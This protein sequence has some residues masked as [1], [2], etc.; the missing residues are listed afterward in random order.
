V[1]LSIERCRVPPSNIPHK[2]RNFVDEVLERAERFGPTSEVSRL[3]EV[4]LPKPVPGQ[5]ALKV[6]A[7]AVALPDILMLQSQ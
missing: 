3:C 5:I 4:E 7:A 1:N 2:Q 6:H